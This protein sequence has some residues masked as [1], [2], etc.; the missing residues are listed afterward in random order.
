ADEI[1]SLNPSGS[2]NRNMRAP[3]GM[4]AGSDSSVP[5]RCLIRCA[6]SST[7]WS[8][9]ICSENPS[10]LARSH[11]LAPSSRL[12]KIRTSPALSEIARSVPSRRCS[13]STLNP[14]TS[15]YQAKLF[16]RSFTV[17]EAESV[18]A[19]KDSGS[20]RIG[21]HGFSCRANGLWGY[22][23]LHAL[24]TRHPIAPPY[25][26]RRDHEAADPLRPRCGVGLRQV[27]R[28]EQHLV[29]GRE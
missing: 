13:R 25:R 20:E 8:V 14:T 11:P 7:F 21:A 18:R 24:V 16:A 10:P 15:W 29:L 22:R 23:R 19:R 5:P 12:I 4:S 9:V 6:I 27:D 17:S 3:Q 1:V 28:V 26:A 2:R